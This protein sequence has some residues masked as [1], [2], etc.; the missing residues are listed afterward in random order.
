MMFKIWYFIHLVFCCY[1]AI[2]PPITTSSVI[3]GG[4]V[5]GWLSAIDAFRVKKWLGV[6]FI[7]GAIGW[8]GEALLVMYIAKQIHAAGRA[9]AQAPAA[10]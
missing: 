9:P 6:M 1:C 3:N 2:A 8:T 7:M 5:T 10:R 4:A